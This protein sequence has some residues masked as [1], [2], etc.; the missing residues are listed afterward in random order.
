MATSGSYSFSVTRDDIVREALLNIKK[1]DGIDPID[2]TIM[3][4]CVRKLNL[5]VKQWM[6][7][8]DFAPGLKV[9]T[10]KHGHLFLHAFTGQYPVGPTYIGWADSYSQTATAAAV[11][12]GATTLLVTSGVGLLAGQYI[13]IALDTGDLFWTTIASVLGTTV[14]LALPMPSS[15]QPNNIVFTYTTIPQ[16]PLLVETASLRDSNANDTPLNIMQSRD[17][18]FLPNKVSPN[19]YGDPTGIYVEDQLGHVNIYTDVSGSNDVSKH[20]AITFMEPV[21]DIINP[22]DEPYYPQEW[23]RPLCWGLSRECAPMFN[24]KW[25]PLHEENYK[26]SLAIARQKGPEIETRYYQPGNDQ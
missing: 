14:T 13:G 26:D 7:R 24:A 17:Y 23:F 2:P 21:Q 16:A 18:D 20:I 12:A 6:G 25:G 11:G 22:T 19:N 5:L 1:I 8:A 10:R 9:W 15:S 3:K 4:D